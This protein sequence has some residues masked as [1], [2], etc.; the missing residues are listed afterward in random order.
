MGGKKHQPSHHNF[1][2]KNVR[3]LHRSIAPIEETIPLVFSTRAAIFGR[4]SAKAYG[5][6]STFL[7]AKKKINIA[8]NPNFS[9]SDQNNPILGS[10]NSP[11]LTYLTTRFPDVRTHFQRRARARKSR[12]LC[13]K[14][15]KKN[16]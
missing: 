16:L 11:H 13:E 5:A 2:F 14:I 1:L 10:F 7:L 3:F 15:A 6:S 12:R 8:T 9:A 4:V